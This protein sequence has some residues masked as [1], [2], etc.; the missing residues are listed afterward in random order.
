MKL[1]TAKGDRIFYK[2]IDNIFVYSKFFN[3]FI[4]HIRDELV[5]KEWPELKYCA[6]RSLRGDT[7]NRNAIA[8]KFAFIYIFYTN[9]TITKDM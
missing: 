3:V 5:N 6:M 9:N 8:A 2:H 4:N 1:L 7:Q